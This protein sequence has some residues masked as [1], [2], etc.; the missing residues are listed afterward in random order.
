MLQAESVP[1]KNLWGSRGEK[2]GTA[3]HV[4]ESRACCGGHAGLC[5]AGRA[6]KA[7]GKVECEWLMDGWSGL[8]IKG[9]RGKESM[10]SVLGKTTG[11]LESGWKVG[12]LSE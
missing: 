12:G 11:A 8:A 10:V 1:W 9:N 4:T 6:Q 3:V 2:R 5:E 7:P